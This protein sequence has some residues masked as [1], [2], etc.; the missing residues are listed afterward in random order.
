MMSG[1]PLAACGQ[2]GPLYLPGAP[3]TLTSPVPGQPELPVE[4]AEE[5]EEESEKQPDDTD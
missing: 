5:A 4:E 1:V 2:K 3:S